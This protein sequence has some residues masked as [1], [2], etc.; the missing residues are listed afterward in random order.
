MTRIPEVQPQHCDPQVA[1]ILANSDIT[2][3][4]R[5]ATG[6]VGHAPHMVK[7]NTAFMSIS[8]RGALLPRRLLELVRLRIAFHNQCRYCMT[9]RHQSA[10][11]DGLTEDVVCSLEKPAEAANLDEREKAALAYADLFVTNHFAICDATYA[12]LRKLFTDPEVVELGIFCGYFLGFG[13]FLASLDITEELPKVFQEDKSRRVGPWESTET[14][15][16]RGL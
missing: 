3:A 13:R 15:V 5:R 2:P 8:M 9:M 1:E 16:V 10:L 14:I 4:Q 11:E 7:A 12:G 6:V